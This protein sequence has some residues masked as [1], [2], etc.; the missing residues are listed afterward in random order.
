[1]CTGIGDERM[2]FEC[3]NH[4]ASAA[5][6]KRGN[7]DRLNVTMGN[8]CGIVLTKLGRQYQVKEI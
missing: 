5:L 7:K 3:R 6:K 8:S 1:M 4:N 2:Q